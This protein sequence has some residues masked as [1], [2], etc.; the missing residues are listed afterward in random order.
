[1]AAL[2]RSI[3][4]GVG[5]PRCGWALR[6]ETL[7]SGSHVC[8]HCRKPFEV[9]RFNPVERHVVVAEVTVL[10]TASSPCARHARNL[11]V[12]ACQR[13][14]QFMC[15]LCRIDTEGKS[16]CP[17][18]FD[19]LTAEEALGSTVTRVKNHA[20]SSAACFMVSTLTCFWLAAP[21]GAAGIYFAA[22][23]LADKRRRGEGDGF[24][25]L[26]SWMTLNLLAFGAGALWILAAAGTFK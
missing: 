10:D 23:G 13:C 7:T 5:C 11:A 16:Y 3:H 21:L 8:T 24:V 25:A 6:H 22:R 4:G 9:A 14:G 1:M 17:G 20:G 19:R 15:A 12:A 18:C 2:A 26:Y